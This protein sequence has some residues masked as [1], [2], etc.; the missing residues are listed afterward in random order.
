[1]A[2]VKTMLMCFDGCLIAGEK[3]D[4]SQLSNETAP[5]KI[6]TALED[7]YTRTFDFKSHSYVWLYDRSPFTSKIILSN[8]LKC[9]ISDFT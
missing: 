7:T 8:P 9:F 1:M 6:I 5:E 2:L 4:G 3:S